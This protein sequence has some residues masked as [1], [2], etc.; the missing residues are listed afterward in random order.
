MYMESRAY[1]FTFH[2]RLAA[3]PS[4]TLCKQRIR[5]LS[6]VEPDMLAVENLGTGLALYGPEVGIGLATEYERQGANTFRIFKVL[7]RSQATRQ[8]FGTRTEATI[9]F[10]T[11][12]VFEVEGRRFSRRDQFGALFV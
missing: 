5:L 2:V 6:Q 9:K 12:S 3:S 10:Q 7:T 11:P 1:C 8:L 4:I